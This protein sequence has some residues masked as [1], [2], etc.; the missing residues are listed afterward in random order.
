MKKLFAI[1]LCSLF[2]AVTSAQTVGTITPAVSVLVGIS[3][4][5]TASTA[6]FLPAVKEFYIWPSLCC[7]NTSGANVVTLVFQGSADGTTYST[8]R[9]GWTIP[10][11]LSGTNIMCEPTKIDATGFQYF[12]LKSIEHPAT[13]ATN[14]IK[15][16]AIKYFYR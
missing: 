12:R 11:T 1:V 9:T 3:T 13:Y 8:T 6:I 16:L 14:G 15:S 2:V 5:T 7:S 4:N 10:I